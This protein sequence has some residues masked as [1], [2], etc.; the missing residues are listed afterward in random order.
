MAVLDLKTNKIIDYY[1]LLK[2]PK[3]ISN[4][5]NWYHIDKIKVNDSMIAVLTAG[6]TLH[7]FEKEETDLI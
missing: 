7:I 2:D 3:K 5:D 4:E 6:G 1:K